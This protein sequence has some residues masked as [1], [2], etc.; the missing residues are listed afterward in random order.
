MSPESRFGPSSQAYGHFSV[1]ARETCVRPKHAHFGAKGCHFRADWVQTRPKGTQT[2]P[3]WTLSIYKDRGT[4][5]LLPQGHRSQLWVTLGQTVL[6]ATATVLVATAPNA[7]NSMRA[8][9]GHSGTPPR[10]ATGRKTNLGG[11][12]TGHLGA[13]GAVCCVLFACCCFEAR[14][15]T[16]GYPNG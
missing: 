8:G 14:R 7:S 3:K 13:F 5:Q 9:N 10:V 16:N 2:G 6:V 11:G 15:L 4:H 12:S 1:L